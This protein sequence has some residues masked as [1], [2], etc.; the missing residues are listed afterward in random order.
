MSGLV[1]PHGRGEEPLY[2]CTRIY[3]L[4]LQ[5]LFE[6]FESGSYKWADDQNLSEVVI[7]DQCPIPR[8]VVERV[9]AIVTMRGPAQFANLSLDQVRTVD[10]A[11]GA[12][13]RT[14]LI[15]CTMSINC[16][17]KLGPEAQ[18]IGWIVMKHIRTF[19]DMIQRAGI[20]KVG[21]ELSMGPESPPGAMVANDGGDAEQVMVTVHSPFFFQWTE[22][23]TPINA[24]QVRGIEARLRSA[25]LPYAA[26]T[27]AGSEEFRRLSQP[28]IRGRA[29][30]SPV[31]GHQRVGEITQTVKT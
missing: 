6:Q 29:I 17:A 27:T 25:S 9:P 7:T 16:I 30:Q 8:E 4:F 10:P 3:L 19:K 18:R 20:H 28:T 11:T 14:D 26:A 2:F 1:E 31:S 13:E 21:D 15:A 22:L 23:S 24:P 12:K 5:G